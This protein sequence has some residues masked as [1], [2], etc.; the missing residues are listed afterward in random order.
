M[1]G[2]GLQEACRVLSGQGP[3]S[4]W[5]LGGVS[6]GRGV[7]ESGGWLT[8]PAP[9]PPTIVLSPSLSLTLWDKMEVRGEQDW[10]LQRFLDEIKEKYQVIKERYN[11]SFV[12][13]IE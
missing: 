5:W 3:C 8:A 9:P 7:S 10:T 12:L 11:S 6:G 1:A 4:N 13:F 2:R